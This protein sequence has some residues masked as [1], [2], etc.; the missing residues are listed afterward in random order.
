M[1]RTP[2]RTRARTRIFRETIAFFKGRLVPIAIALVGLIISRFY[3]EIHTPLI[4]LVRSVV[5]LLCSYGI[6]FVGAFVVNTIRVPGLLDA[7]SGEQI[8]NLEARAETAETALKD[9]STRYQ[10]RLKFADLM[11]EGEVLA[12]ELRRGLPQFGGWLEKRRDWIGRTN[13]ALIDAEFPT[14]AADF[15]HA[16]EFTPDIKGIANDAYWHRFYGEQLESS[17]TRLREIISRR[18]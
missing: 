13:Q 2:F 11:R 6:A 12:D 8:N 7:E 1:E 17:R 16:A 10:V 15:R 5:I 4:F 18:V 9:K 14:D 3:G